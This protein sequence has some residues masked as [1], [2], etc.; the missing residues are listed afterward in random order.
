MIKAIFLDF[1]GT[2]YSHNLGGIPNSTYKALKK[3]K[4]KGILTFLCTGRAYSELEWFDLSKLDIDGIIV[5]NGQL[6]FDKNHNIIYS[7]PIEGI[8]K[9]KLVEI[10]K[11]KKHPMHIST[12]DDIYMSFVN[13]VVVVV[14]NAISSKIPD[15]KEYQGEEFYMASIY[16][17]RNSR[18]DD[19]D[20]LAKYG[21]I[22]FWH[23]DACDIVPK[24]VSKSTGIDLV[25]QKY[26]IDV[27][28]TLAVGD[29]ENDIAMLERCGVGVAMGNSTQAVKEISDYITDDIDNDGLF[30]AF[31]YFKL[32]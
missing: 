2:T 12:A 22:T 11:Q 19:L 8:L 14:Q 20:E 25:C 4:E 6:A 27:K 16:I 10:F 32:I 30:K 31:K 29:G 26:N 15:I 17:D 28:D 23:K 7:R 9:E 24:G 21:E 3:V 5:S 1:D 18:T 13:D